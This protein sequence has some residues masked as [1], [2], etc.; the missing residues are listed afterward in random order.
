M[1]VDRETNRIVRS[2]LEAGVTAL[3]DRVLDDVLDQ[4]PATRQRRAIIWPARRL[5]EMN[6]ALAFALAAAAVVAIALTSSALFGLPGTGVGG[7]GDEP[8]PDPTATPIPWPT[9]YGND[10]APGT[11]IS[12]GPTPVRSI[13]TV[14]AGWLTCG[15]GREEFAVCSR[16]A[17]NAGFAV[18]LIDNV[19]ANPCD[20]SR[21]LLDPPVGESVDDLV[22][23]MSSLAGFTATDPTDVSVSGFSGKQFELRAT[24]APACELDENGLGAWSSGAD[25]NGVGPGE[26]NLV[27]II[28]A[29][30]LRV[31]ITAAYQPYTAAGVVAELRAML[32]SAQIVR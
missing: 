5:F 14:P 15:V 25:I 19:V 2:W 22:K 18:L 32:E 9:G 29:D 11:Y 23:A 13:L 17:Q 4:L 31:V 26:V 16:P 1:S 20:A 10:L 21:A 28:D 12:D 27:R 3:P 24:T 7:P 6:K 8:P 30:G